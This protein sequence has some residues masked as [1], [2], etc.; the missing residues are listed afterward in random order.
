MPS[1]DNILTAIRLSDATKTAFKAVYREPEDFAEYLDITENDEEI[2]SHL[3][4]F[5]NGNK[6]DEHKLLL[7][8]SYFVDTT[9]AGEDWSTL[10]GA[11]FAAWKLKRRQA[12]SAAKVT[13]T[14]TGTPPLATS[15]PTQL[16]FSN[17]T[18]KKDQELMK[19]RANKGTLAML[20]PHPSWLSP[21]CH[22]TFRI[23]QHAPPQIC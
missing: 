5:T 22:I 13:K 16:D 10:T 18:L 14:S 17:K 3:A 12:A 19:T 1:V 2:R 4:L 11:T 7:L 9:A 20:S 15:T 23:R 8:V 6:I 21:F